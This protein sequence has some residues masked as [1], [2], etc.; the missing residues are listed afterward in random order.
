MYSPA[1]QCKLDIPSS[2]TEYLPRKKINLF[3]SIYT[4]SLYTKCIN[5][6]GHLQ[7]TREFVLLEFQY[8]FFHA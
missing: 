6:T 1:K 2:L 7:I 8:V 4:Y 5:Y 3:E